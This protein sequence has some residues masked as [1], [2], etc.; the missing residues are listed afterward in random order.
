MLN[1]KYEGGFH[2]D[3]FPERFAYMAFAPMKSFITLSVGIKTITHTPFGL[4]LKPHKVVVIETGE[5]D[6]LHSCDMPARS[7]R[8]LAKKLEQYAN[9]IDGED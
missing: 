9:A 3:P 1:P 7:A 2:L 8:A 6:D 4:K 5:G